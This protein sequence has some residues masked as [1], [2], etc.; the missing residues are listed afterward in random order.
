MRFSVEILE[1]LRREI[2]ICADSEDDAL[3]IARRQY[4][5]EIIVLDS[6]DFQE[7]SFAVKKKIGDD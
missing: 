7:V 4:R 2:T 1:T 6:G 3:E 5:D